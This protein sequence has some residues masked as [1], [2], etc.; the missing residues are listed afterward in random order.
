MMIRDYKHLIGLKHSYGTNSFKVC[1]SEMLMVKRFILWK[2]II[3][4]C[5]KN[6][7]CLQHIKNDQLW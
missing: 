4:M 1:E 7:S 5:L 6:T 3:N 2:I